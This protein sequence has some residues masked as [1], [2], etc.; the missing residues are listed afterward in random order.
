[1]WWHMTSDFSPKL[2]SR[3]TRRA[4]SLLEFAIVLA[5]MGIVLGALWGVV[6]IVNENTKRG[7]MADQ[8]ALMVMNIRSFYAGR[9]F[10]ADQ[11]GNIDAVNVTNYLLHQGVLPAEQNRDRT[12]GTWVADHPWGRRSA[13]GAAL[14][15]GGVAVSGRDSGGGNI[16]NR[17]FMIELRGLKFSSCVAMV[18][19]LAGSLPTGLLE[20]DINLAALV[21]PF[22]AD[23]A[24]NTC[25][26][27]ADNALGLVY[28]LREQG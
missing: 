23:K 24:A 27:G 6:A 25:A 3:R 12:L 20:I 11:A 17:A 1:M 28:R 5:I 18:S 8:V 21:V 9:T 13:T 15:A 26:A 2:L 7:Q 22:T 14:P 4:F 10:L 16:S 19:K